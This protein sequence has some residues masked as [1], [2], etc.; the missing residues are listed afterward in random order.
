MATMLPPV[1]DESTVSDAERRVFA[2]VKH[3][4]DTDG[5]VVLHSLG[6]SHR[7]R[8]PYGEIDF[9]V[10]MPGEGVLCLEVKGGRIACRDGEWETTDRHGITRRLNRSP[11]L[12]A[13]EGMFALRDAVNQRA[14]GQVP[15]N[16]VFAYAVVMPDIRFAL[17]T[18]ECEP[19]QVID[20]D[21]LLR[22]VSTLLRRVVRETAALIR[23][24]LAGEPTAASIRAIRQ[25]LRPDF[26]L[27]VARTAQIEKTEAKLLQLTEDQYATLDMLTEN[28]R[29]LVYGAAGTGKTMLALEFARRAA[30]AEQRTLFL[31]FNRLLGE[32]LEHQCQ[33]LSATHPLTAGS[34]HKL[35]RAIIL[36]SPLAGEFTRIEQ[37]RDAQALF[38]EA[39]P[40]HGA[41]A[42]AERQP[43]DV[44]V[45]DEAQDMLSASAVDVLNAWLRGG[46]A[47]GRWAIF[48]DFERQAIFGGQTA[49][50]LKANLVQA[51]P[52]F[53]RAGLKVNCRNSRNIGQ[54]T[55]LLSGF[56]AP[57]YRM[58]QVPGLPVDYR[59]YRSAEDQ[60]RVLSEILRS[61][62]AE[63]VRPIDV[64]V[65]SQYRLSNSAI[66]GIDG[67]R[68]FQIAEM[69]E[70]V[71]VHGRTPV[72]RFATV[73]SFKGMESPV[74]VLCDVERVTDAAPQ[75]LLYVAMS[76]ARAQLILLVDESLRRTV[77]D[78]I[79]AGLRVVWR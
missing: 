78:I 14:Q 66:A 43:Y 56:D 20:R 30:L 10:L 11:F 12:Q 6:L 55:A 48:G 37:G 52:Q 69:G 42:L 3:A 70:A 28:S 62:L 34:Y 13:R 74:V 41:L 2:L 54:E 45:L 40:E 67:G 61:L 29:C 21:S 71:P 39:Y 77:A 35:L 46:L 50:A 63:G 57:P 64:V 36:D 33:P 44:L 18:P 53:T 65:L 5:W 75:S 25:L 7:G 51:A 19:W 76:R 22:P 60:R 58:G 8:K 79:R 32:W 9:V 24:P 26:E 4:P 27:V 72:I 73:Q 59:Y 17:R 16:L 15:D 47:D 31:C 1:I 68:D 23:P 38:G 49:E